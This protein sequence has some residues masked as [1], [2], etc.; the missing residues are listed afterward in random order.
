VKKALLLTL[1]VSL[2][3]VLG[4]PAAALAAPHTDSPPQLQLGWTDSAQPG[5]A[6]T[7][8]GETNLPIGTR[9]DEAGV[10]HT[11]RVYATFDLSKYEGRKMY[12]GTVFVEERDAADCTKRSIELWRTKAVST[13]PTWNKA[14]AELTKL[15][16]IQTPELC[17]RA[18]ISFDVSVAL[19]DAIAAKQ[20]RVT[21]EFR[22]SAAA[23]TD[24]TYGRSLYAYRGV[25]LSTQ[26]NAVPKIDNANLYTGGFACTQLKPYPP[27]GGL[28][29]R[30]QALGLDAD[31]GERL[32]TEFAIWPVGTPDARTVYPVQNAVPGRVATANVPLD[33]LTT[34][35]AYGW[36]ARTSD[37]TDTSAWS[38]KC[39][40]KYDGVAPS[41]PVVTVGPVVAGAYPKFTFDGHGDK[42][43]A[44]FQY[45]WWS[46]P[47][48][49]ACTS[50]GPVGQLEC[51]DPFQQSGVT[52]LTTPGG[53]V[54]LP[55]NPD[56]SGPIRLAVRSVDLAGNVSPTI[57]QDVYVPRSSPTVTLE[58]DAP[59][60]NQAVVL[61]LT[62]APGVTGVTEYEI[63]HPGDS[64]VYTRT[65]DEDGVAYYRFFASDPNGPQATVRSVSSTGFRSAPA[66][67]Q[68]T[69]QPWPGVTVAVADGTASFTFAPP[70]GWDEVA[71]YRY[72]FDDD[73]STRT[74]TS[75]SSL[76]WTPETPG[77]HT[78]EV[79]ALKA[80]GTVS[81][82]SRYVEFEV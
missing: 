73:R 78:I 49:S 27:L 18:T 30:L 9:V 72:Q 32:T 63:T 75:D 25:R 45:G 46:L 44:G 31:E 42:D 33:T 10:A 35:Q 26:S 43:I 50:P 57:Y 71:Q 80:D 74:V 64:T 15:D 55:L 37:G 6:F 12:G 16:E 40:F 67:W 1:S 53:S 39:F 20:R 8:D 56:T 17:N 41:A 52:K 36:Q 2:G 4:L 59:E 14:P 66:T 38:K 58:G 76:D 28:A 51:K 11:S 61:K 69:F 7:A 65:A 22:V 34:G 29:G 47:V 13:T 3:A 21:F 79:W 82:L 19:A 68:Q 81:D 77:P 5:K 70:P 54:T 62:P 60:W 48:F 24:P 23:E